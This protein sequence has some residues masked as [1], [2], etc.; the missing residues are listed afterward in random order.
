MGLSLLLIEHHMDFLASLVDDVVVLDSGR[1]IYRGDMKG[2][3]ENAEV[4][5]AYL[6]D[7]AAGHA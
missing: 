3:R 7:E 6:G 1:I 5:G 2:M 4:I